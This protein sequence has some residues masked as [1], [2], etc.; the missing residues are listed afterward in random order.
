MIGSEYLHHHVG[1]IAGVLELFYLLTS[2]IL[3]LDQKL[4]KPALPG[5]RMTCFDGDSSPMSNQ[6]TFWS[7]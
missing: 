6:R 3:L 7:F 5:P 4:Y 1:L 2:V